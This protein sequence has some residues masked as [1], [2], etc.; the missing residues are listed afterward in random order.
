MSIERKGLEVA[1][2]GFKF[3]DDEPGVFE[4]YASVF[5]GVD[6][7]GDTILPGAYAV[8]LSNRQRPIQMRWNHFGPVIGK[9]LEAREDDKGL[10]VKGQIVTGH[11]VGADAYALMKAGAVTGLS[12][13]FRIPPGGSEKDGKLR[14]LKRIDLIE[15][16]VVEE[17]ADLSAR[18]GDVKSAIETCDSL[19]EIESI[20]RD[21]G[22]FSRADATA[23][24]ARVKSLAHGDRAESESPS[25]DMAAAIMLHANTIKMR[26]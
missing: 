17:P 26:N 23:L 22:G 19:K 18:I 13:G 14:K 24:V 8:T 21:A 6:S 11:S 15:I 4:G 10:W 9:W 5:N 1:E 20:L 16:S 2:V 3:M 25:I 12:I 7:Y